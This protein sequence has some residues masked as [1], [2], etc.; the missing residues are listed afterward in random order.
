MPAT[1]GNRPAARQVQA[2]KP[3][4]RSPKPVDWNR[5]VNIAGL[6]NRL[7][8][9]LSL[10]S[11]DEYVL[12]VN[13]L[14]RSPRQTKTI[15]LAV[16]DSS[17]EQLATNCY[18]E[19][20]PELTSGSRI[21]SLFNASKLH[22]TTGTVVSLNEASSDKALPESVR[23][24]NLF[25]TDGD[26]SDKKQYTRLKARL[27]EQSPRVAI[28]LDEQQK[29]EELA[30]GLVTDLI[31]LLENQVLDKISRECGPIR[32]VD[33]NGRFCILL[34]PWLNKLQGGKTKINGFVRPSDFRDNV[35]EPFSNHCDM[36][37]LNSAL[38]PGQQLL[39]LLSHE[40]THAAVSSIR[41]AS[42]CSLPDEEDW[43]NEGI[44][45]MMEPGYTNRD[46]RISE[47]FRSPESY[48]LVVS[49][50]YRAQLWR[51]HGCRGAVNLFLNWCNQRESYGRFANRFTHHQLTGTAK[52]EQLTSTR[53]PE[54]FRLWS[55]DLARQSLAYNTQQAAPNTPEPLIH[56]GRFVLAG[57][58]IHNW[59][60]SDQKHQ[61][62]KIAS[63]ASGFLRLNS[64]SQLPEK[65]MINV[66]GFPSM[67]L[68]LLKI[69]QTAQQV[70]L[71]ANYTSAENPV[72]SISEFVAV[73]L[74]CSH[75][76]NSKVE[77]ISLEFNGAYLSQVARQ[78]QKLDISTISSASIKQRSGL[79]VTMLNSRTQ[80]K[81]QQTDFRVS[82][83]RKNFDGK[84]GAES[85][86][87]K[88]IL[89]SETQERSVVQAE[90]NLPALSP[91]RLAKGVSDTA[92]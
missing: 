36:L 89:I 21:S 8:F 10:S 74:H 82:I 78:P 76:V 85:L 81:K 25:V 43:L 18:F 7:C 15:V 45:H 29:P 73:H 90:L 91:R 39:D 63:T 70:S 46:Y 12:I 5:P 56:C 20:T 38:K 34:S 32:D 62:L 4:Y 55:L 60:L 66:Q 64:N 54:L 3:V 75:P 14:D 49:D 47:F 33:G 79:Q 58:A 92:K 40:V 59:N 61:S 9:P 80:Q 68:T 41:T 52:I 67:Q 51:N 23:Y 27:I 24:F 16:D 48:P 72:D 1:S 71:Q 30:N 84:T 35:A 53:F 65:R 44:A 2:F 57:P 19:N 22:R 42:G 88:V 87:W 11:E 37:Y 13:N 83:P 77:M 50:Y 17:G 26:L 28:Y 86:S 6:K 69:E 31:L